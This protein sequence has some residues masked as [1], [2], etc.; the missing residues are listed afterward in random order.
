[1]KRVFGAEHPDTLRSMCNL[2][3]TWKGRGR[4]TEALGL[5][6]KECVQLRTRVYAITILTLYPYI[7]LFCIESM[8]IFEVISSTKMELTE[9]GTSLDDLYL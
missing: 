4:D 5:L 3:F 7:L 9:V 8:E 2:A 1:M 6:K